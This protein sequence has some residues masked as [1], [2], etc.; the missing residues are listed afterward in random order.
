MDVKLWL[1]RQRAADQRAQTDEAARLQAMS[2]DERA[3]ILAVL[4]EDGQ[5]L[6]RAMPPE[7]R[8]RARA[9]EPLPESSQLALKRLRATAR[10]HVR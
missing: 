8:A 1:E 7:L 6:L 9:T 2:V 5:R 10:L 3:R 4:C